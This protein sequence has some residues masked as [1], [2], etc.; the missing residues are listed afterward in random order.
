MQNKDIRFAKKKNIDADTDKIDNLIL[1]DLEQNGTYTTYNFPCG[2][3]NISDFEPGIYL[4]RLPSAF[5]EAL[6][7]LDLYENVLPFDDINWLFRM[8]EEYPQMPL[9]YYYIGKFLETKKDIEE[10]GKNVYLFK[11]YCPNTPLSMYEELR[12]IY[13]NEENSNFLNVFF[14]KGRNLHDYFPKRKF[15]YIEEVIDILCYFFME[16]LEE[17]RFE[18]AEQYL[19]TLKVKLGENSSYLT[20]WNVK[21]VTRRLP[22]WKLYFFR[23]LLTVA[24]ILLLCLLYKGI[25]WI[26]GLF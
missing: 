21:L 23:F 20:K 4:D 5:S 16:A 10:T 6:R 15:F 8:R 18:D 12:Y 25:S 22:T 13:P 24:A 1:K 19:N 3:I 26:I 2:A 7:I 14:T 17:K 9:F 11:V